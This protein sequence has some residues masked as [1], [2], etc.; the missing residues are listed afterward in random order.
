MP[1]LA[2]L[3]VV[4]LGVGDWNSSNGDTASEDGSEGSNF[5]LRLQD[6][7]YLYRVDPLSLRAIART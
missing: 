1:R 2:E 7:L 4:V 3:M 5:G 6:N